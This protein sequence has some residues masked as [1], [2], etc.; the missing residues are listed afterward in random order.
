M[1]D[2]GLPV[3]LGRFGGPGILLLVV[4]CTFGFTFSDSPVCHM[5]S[6]Q[7]CV[8][9]IYVQLL[10]SHLAENRFKLSWMRPHMHVE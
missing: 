1:L 3:L 2:D 9:D 4:L 5:Y 6:C 8:A 10:H 7:A